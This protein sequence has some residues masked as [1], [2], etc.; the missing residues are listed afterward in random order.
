MTSLTL[1]YCKVASSTLST[2]G[3]LASTTGGTLGNNSITLSTNTGYGELYS[4]SSETFPNGGGSIGNP[5]GNG[6]LWDVT[7]L[8]GQ[9][10]LAGNWTPTVRLQLGG[11]GVTG[12]LTIDLYVRLYRRS[13]AGAYTQIG[14]TMSKTGNSIG[15]AVT[16]FTFTA[17]SQ[18]LFVFSGGDKF[19]SDVWANV[20]ANNATGG[21][22]TIK[23]FSTTT[24]GTGVNTAQLVSPGYQQAVLS[25]VIGHR[26]MG[27][28]Q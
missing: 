9:Q 1:Y 6:F 4:L 15:T 27:R 26:S 24:S 12:T 5:S 22:A 3:A 10:F 18:P 21:T 19:Y 2:A 16:S 8:E 23:L 11:T 17:V 20:T 13:S 28:I 7:T 14:T 25:S